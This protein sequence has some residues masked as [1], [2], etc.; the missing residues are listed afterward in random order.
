ML[1]STGRLPVARDFT[2]E[3]SAR[4][5]ARQNAAQSMAAAN[6][7]LLIGNPSPVCA[8]PTVGRR[9]EF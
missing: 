8:G 7:F 4:V 1:R 6:D 9:A 2:R 5:R 3:R